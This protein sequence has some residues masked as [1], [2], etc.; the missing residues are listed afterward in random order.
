LRSALAMANS[1]I[2]GFH[3]GRSINVL[4]SMSRPKYVA[5]VGKPAINFS[6]DTSSS[7]PRTWR[8][9]RRAPSA[10]SRGAPGRAAS[11]RVAA[12]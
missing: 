9:V 12:R 11:A 7:S 8:S 2:A 4:M 5:Y 10:T 6:C 3:T 1:D